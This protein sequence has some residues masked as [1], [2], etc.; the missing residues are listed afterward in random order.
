[1]NRRTPVGSWDEAD[2]W[3]GTLVGE[4]GHYYHQTLLIPNILK[5]LPLREGSSLLDLGCGSGVLARHLPKGIEYVGIDSAKGLLDQAKRQTKG[6]QFILADAS[7]KLPL[8]RSDFDAAIFLLSL[9]N[10]EHGKGAIEQAAAHLKIGG[11]LLLILNHPCFR[12]PRQSDWGYDEAMK[13]QYRRV[14]SYMSDLKIPIAVHPSRQQQSKTTYSFHHP[15]STYSQWLAE[16][17]LAIANMQEWC[18]D[19]TSEGSKAKAENRARK[20]I[21]LFLAISAQKLAV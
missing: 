13:L 9:Q 12:V 2:R 7:Q 21:P 14:N 20:E 11:Q 5:L 3:Y 10:M 18:S 19:K 17:H 15:L 8:E 1:M 6:G 4:K 16:N